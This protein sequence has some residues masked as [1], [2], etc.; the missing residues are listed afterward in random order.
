MLSKLLVMFFRFFDLLVGGLL[1]LVVFGLAGGFF[2]LDVLW[3]SL[4]INSRDGSI[5]IMVKSINC[6][7]SPFTI[8]SF[9]H[10]RINIIP[11]RF[12]IFGIHLLSLKRNIELFLTRLEHLVE[13]LLSGVSSLVRSLNRLGS[14]IH[15]GVARK[16]LS[17]LLSCS[18]VLLIFYLNSGNFL[19]GVDIIIKVIGTDLLFFNQ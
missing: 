18:I 14:T 7:E 19:S 17:C 16:A 11:F 1:L 13:V 5:V 4:A 9:V 12:G 3:N 15:L 10:C 6:V 2:E 8:F